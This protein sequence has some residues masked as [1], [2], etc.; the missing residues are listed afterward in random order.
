MANDTVSSPLVVSGEARGTWYFEAD[1]PVRLYDAN[2]SELAVGI[3]Q[4]QDDWMTEDFVTF[5][6]TLEFQAPATKT[7]YL[8]LEKSNPSDLPENAAEVKI[9]VKFN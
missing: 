4:A 7:G 9:P 2:G 6:V 3:A 1:F 5:M 8:I